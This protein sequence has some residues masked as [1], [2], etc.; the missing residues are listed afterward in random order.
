M[1]INMSHPAAFSTDINILL[2]ETYNYDSPFTETFKAFTKNPIQDLKTYRGK[3]VCFK[4]V[5]LPLLP[6][7]IF[8]LYYNT[9]IV[10]KIIFEVN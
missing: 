8:G 10:C 6:R 4:N 5:V 1:H 7:M 9:P 2:W 3:V